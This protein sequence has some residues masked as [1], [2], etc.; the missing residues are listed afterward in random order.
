MGGLIPARL[1]KAM[2]IKKSP[3]RAGKANKAYVVENAAIAC[4]SGK[5]KVKSDD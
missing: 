4:E 2:S 5:T 3:E 1:R